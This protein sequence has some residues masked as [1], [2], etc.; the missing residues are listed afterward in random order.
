MLEHTVLHLGDTGHAVTSP[1]DGLRHQRHRAAK[2]RIPLLEH[3]L[4]VRDDRPPRELLETR[5]LKG[6]YPVPDLR[7]E[8]EVEEAPPV[9]SFFLAKTEPR[10]MT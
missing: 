9:V 7:L 5:D 8:D 1:V 4:R 6:E 3:I 10:T 2:Q